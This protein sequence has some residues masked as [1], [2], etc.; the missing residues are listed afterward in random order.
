M[1]LLTIS[2]IVNHFK[3]TFADSSSSEE[4]FDWKYA[5]EFI[6]SVATEDYSTVSAKY[7]RLSKY[8]YD[9]LYNNKNLQPLSSACTCALSGNGGYG[10]CLTPDQKQQ[11]MNFVESLS[12]SMKEN[13]GAAS[14]SADESNMVLS[15]CSF[16]ILLIAVCIVVALYFWAIIT[17]CNF[18]LPLVIVCL[19]LLFMLLG[20]PMY[21]I[22]LAYLFSNKTFGKYPFPITQM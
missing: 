11:L 3:S 22:I 1:D 14:S 19:C 9:N 5:C 6:K 21:S 13:F 10:K 8:Q 2:G 20:Q 18:K 12:S 15:G 4:G 17:V 7:P 16:I